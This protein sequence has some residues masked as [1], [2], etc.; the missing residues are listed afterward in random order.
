LPSLVLFKTWVQSR[1]A[2][3]GSSISRYPNVITLRK[4]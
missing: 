1:P 4:H 3:C 2:P